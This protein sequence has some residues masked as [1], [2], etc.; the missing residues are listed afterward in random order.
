LIGFTGFVA[1]ALDATVTISISPAYW[2]SRPV[3]AI[4][5]GLMLTVAQRS[6]QAD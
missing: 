3:M 5:T 1:G 6:P 4:G 2:D